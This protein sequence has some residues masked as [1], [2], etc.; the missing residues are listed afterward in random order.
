LKSKSENA[1]ESQ[2]QSLPEDKTL[3]TEY[4]SNIDDS[5]CMMSMMRYRKI[6]PYHAECLYISNI[7]RLKLYTPTH[8]L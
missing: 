5:T 8:D 4:H 6:P 2:N 1:C 3:Y 7:Y